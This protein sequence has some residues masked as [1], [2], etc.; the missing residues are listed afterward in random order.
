[1]DTSRNMVKKEG[2]VAVGAGC[3]CVI[4]VAAVTS[5]VCGALVSHLG[6]VTTLTPWVFQSAIQA[7][8]IYESNSS[9]AVLARTQSSLN[10]L[11]LN[12][13]FAP[14]PCKTL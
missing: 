4:A 7:P 9:A 3:A 14:A 13:S 10:T 5:G 12:A 1:M 2:M 11:A 6:G 8:D